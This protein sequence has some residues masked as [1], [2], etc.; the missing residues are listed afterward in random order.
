MSNEIPEELYVD[1]LN[2]STYEGILKPD[3]YHDTKYIRSDKYETLRVAL[4]KLTVGSCSCLTKTPE[5]E[6][7]E[8][9]CRYK[10]AAQALQDTE[11]P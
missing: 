2:A 11:E 3:D 10:I 6:H 9:T 4:R 8:D 1:A 7:H 5:I